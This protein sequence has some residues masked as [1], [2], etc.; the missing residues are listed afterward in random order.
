[1]EP[2]SLKWKFKTGLPVFSSPAVGPD[3]TVYVGSDDGYLYAIYSSSYG[4]ADSPWPMFGHDTM[5]TRRSIFIVISSPTHP[6]PHK[7]YASP[8]VKFIWEP[9]VGGIIGYYILL[10]RKLSSLTPETAQDYV[11]RNS[12]EYRGLDDG[13]WFFHIMG[14]YNTGELT[15]VHT[16]QVNIYTTPG[17]TSRTHPDQDLWYQE[18]DVS[19][20]WSVEDPS[21]ARCCYY[22]LDRTSDTVP[23]KSTGTKVTGNVFSL[24]VPS[25][26]E[27]YVHLVWEDELGNLS[28][29]AHYRI[30]VDTTPPGPVR[31]LTATLVEGGV[32]LRWE[33]PE[34]NASGVGSYQIYRSKFKG[35]IGSRIA[36]GV[37]G[38]E[39]LDDVAVG[40]GEA[41]YYT[42]IPLD[43]AGNKQVEGNIQATVTMPPHISISANFHDFGEV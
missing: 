14:E 18:E 7:W 4:L 19:I 20:S 3:G 39:Y 24:S 22:I 36:E 40:M 8:D 42:V 17:L 26:G 43:R 30:R 35:A 10:D 13:T 9:K 34:D 16:F 5:H 21:S 41:Y 27:W 6:W 29:A 23:T 2:G 25:D 1:Q 28:K 38:T 32:K 15:P 33:E 37:E 11:I 31:Q 12:K